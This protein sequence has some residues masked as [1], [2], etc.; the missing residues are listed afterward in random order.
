MA[1]GLLPGVVRFPIAH[2]QV[3]CHSQLEEQLGGFLLASRLL[4]QRGQ[5]LVVIDGLVEGPF[6]AGLVPG[7][8]Q[9]LDCLFGIAR[10]APVV[11]DEPI[12]TLGSVLVERLKPLSRPVV[13]G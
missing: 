1:Q 9:I 7:Q 10:S 2:R 5:R 12:G 3:E 11:C 13:E 6:I 4:E 8:S